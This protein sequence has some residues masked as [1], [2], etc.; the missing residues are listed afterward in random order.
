MTQN[1][2]Y[3]QLTASGRD[4]LSTQSFN[5]DCPSVGAAHRSVLDTGGMVPNNP[6]GRTSCLHDVWRSIC[7]HFASPFVVDSILTSHA[8]QAF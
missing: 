8:G 6:F 1:W 2:F 3:T 4:V 5:Q 7:G